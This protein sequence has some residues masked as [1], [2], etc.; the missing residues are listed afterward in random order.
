VWQAFEDEDAQTAYR[1]VCHG[2]LV[3]L[4]SHGGLWFVNILMP[5]EEREKTY[6]A[7]PGFK[8]GV[9]LEEAQR[10]ALELTR[11]ARVKLERK[12]RMLERE[13]VKDRPER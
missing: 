9:A 13:R 2:Y 8:K 11:Q 12:L 7:G 3:F 10:I 6:M 5:E 4:T 1:A